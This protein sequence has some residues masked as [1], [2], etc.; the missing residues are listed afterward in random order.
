MKKIIQ[1]ICIIG[2]IVL[3]LTACGKIEAQKSDSESFS[4]KLKEIQPIEDAPALFVVTEINNQNEIEE[5]MSVEELIDANFDAFTEKILLNNTELMD[6][7]SR[8]MDSSAGSAELK[9]DY[10]NLSAEKGAFIQFVLPEVDKYLSID[11]G[12]DYVISFSVQVD[13]TVDEYQFSVGSGDVWLDMFIRNQSDFE[14]GVNT[15]G[16]REHPND[17]GENDINQFFYNVGEWYNVLI[18]FDSSLNYTFLMWEDKD[19]SCFMFMKYDLSDDIDEKYQM[20]EHPIGFQMV[21]QT[22]LDESYFNIKTF[23]IFESKG[24][25]ELL[26]EN[27]ASYT[28]SNDDEKYRIAVALFNAGDYYDAYLLLEDLNGYST[29]QSY[30]DECER[31]LQTVKIESQDIANAIGSAMAEQGM[32][33]YDY[34]YVYQTE[35]IKTLNLNK[36]KVDDLSFLEYFPNLDELNLDGC[37]IADITPL[38]DVYS[39]KKLSLAENNISDVLPLYNLTNLQYLDLS[40]NLIEDVYGLS[41]LNSLTTLNLSGNNLIYLDG[42]YGLENLE[43]VDLSY[44]FIYSVNALNNSNVKDLNILNTN[45]LALGAV[46]DIET[47][48]VL[49]AGF[50][51]QWKFDAQSYMLT[52]KYEDDTHFHMGMCGQLSTIFTDL[53]N[54][55][56]LYLS[57]AYNCPPQ[58]DQFQVNE[59]TVDMLNLPEYDEY[60]IESQADL[61]QLGELVCEQNLIVHVEYG[62]DSEAVKLSIPDYVRNLY[63]H[64]DI[65]DEIKIELDCVDNVGLERVVVGNIYISEDDSDGFGSGNF[66][67]ENLDGLS[68]CVNLREIYIRSAKISDISGLADSKK[69]EIIDLAKNNI[70]DITSLSN[71]VNLKELNLSNNSIERIEALENCSRLQNIYLY[72][73]PVRYIDKLRKLPLI[74]E[75]RT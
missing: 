9:D 49:K 32:T 40:N 65:E 39:L 27:N 68:G 31:L 28:Y 3:C 33:I 29:S 7:I 26:D 55:S 72:G 62:N 74:K 60:W 16:Q 75:L 34:L 21:V 41:N 54:L 10:I 66:I 4:V 14:F 13:A 42:L 56:A 24:S 38:K 25:L 2:M 58:I 50:R 61:E 44:N 47:L 5:P 6:M 53:E 15:N 37:A 11:S 17:Y 30:L 59:V 67:L 46:A 35:A 8:G 52:K 57:S 69:L 22:P 48:Q 36:C 45:I 20:N 12:K 51:Y 73:N 64:S 70:I 43:T 1:I 71:M 63:I 18:A 19:P 23:G